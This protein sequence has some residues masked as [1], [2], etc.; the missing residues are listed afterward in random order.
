M[1][2]ETL[3]ALGCS[4]LLYQLW[5]H[6]REFYLLE[7]ALFVTIRL[8]SLQAED[9]IIQALKQEAILA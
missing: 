6:I 3:G 4:S 5:L 8:Q 7:L 1:P 2:Q 9:V